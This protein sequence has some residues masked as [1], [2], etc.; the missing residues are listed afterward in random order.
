M[1]SVY[2]SWPTRKENNYFKFDGLYF[3]LNSMQTK[4][5]RTTY[6]GLEWLGDV[7][8]LFDGIRIIAHALILPVSTLAMRDKILSQ[9]YSMLPEKR[10]FK[11]RRERLKAFIAEKPRKFKPGK[12]IFS[13]EMFCCRRTKRARQLKYAE[14]NIKKQLDLKKFF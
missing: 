6:S 2:N 10:D 1:S 11:N 5:E 4:I 12:I 9:V 13:R 3:E 8:G 14:E 7:G